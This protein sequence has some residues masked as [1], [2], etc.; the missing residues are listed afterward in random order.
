LPIH[1]IFERSSEMGLFRLTADKV[2]PIFGIRMTK[3]LRGELHSVV[4]MARSWPPRDAC[5]L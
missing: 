2:V 5:R 3:R 4:E 1:K